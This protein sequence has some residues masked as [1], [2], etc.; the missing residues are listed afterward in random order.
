MNP[1]QIKLVQQSFARVLPIADQAA[2]MF[3]QHL[4]ELD[5]ELEIL[6][7]GDMRQQ[8]KRLMNML[9]V[10]VRGLNDLP[11]FAPGLRDLGA[12]HNFYGVKPA[13]YATV[14]SA[15]LWT[16]NEGLGAEFT[17]E[18]KEAWT[19]VYAVLSDTMKSAAAA[20]AQA[21]ACAPGKA[22]GAA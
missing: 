16:L 14:G 6:F 22:V 13:D 2:A 1:S 17:D 7:K 21:D 19:A 8:G 3:Y 9:A 5:P 20:V 15:L 18:V 11:G 10:A 12:R 4:F